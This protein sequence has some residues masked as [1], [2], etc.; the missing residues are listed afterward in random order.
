MESFRD[1]KFWECDLW[2]MWGYR[3]LF[4]IYIEV[5]VGFLLLLMILVGVAGDGYR[6]GSKDGTFKFYGL[7]LLL[8]LEDACGGK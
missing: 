5:M 4:M 2:F 7:D 6:Q 1:C 3:C 8:Y